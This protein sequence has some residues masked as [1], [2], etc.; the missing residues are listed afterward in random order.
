MTCWSVFSGR[1]NTDKTLTHFIPIFPLSLVVYPGEKLNLHIFEPRYRQLITEC[2]AQQK[3][4]GIPCVVKDALQELGTLVEITE[5]TKTYEDGRMDIRTRGISVFK[6]LEVVKEIPD[7]LYSGAIVSPRLN[8]NNGSPKLMRKILEDARRLHEQLGVE[9]DFGK[10]DEALQSYDVA[11]HVGLKPEDE[12]QV[13]EYEN[14]LHRQE[15][16]KRYLSEALQ[17]MKDMQALQEKIRLNGHFRELK[18]W[19]L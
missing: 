1:T 17:L 14:E 19:D 10:P 15:F 13:L 11:H 12:Y 6:V 16:L 7:K 2:Q 18:G 5:I 8:F 9:K 4:F 3:P